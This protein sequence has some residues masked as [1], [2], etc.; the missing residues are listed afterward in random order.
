MITLT[1]TLEKF[2]QMGEKTGWT[3]ITVP[4]KT[5]QKLKPGNR[6]S[7]RV[8]GFLDDYAIQKTALIPMGEGDFIIPINAAMRKGLGKQKGA[9]V[10]V[11]LEV[12]AAPM[13]PP[14][15]LMECLMDEPEALQ[16][17]NS[18]PQ[19]H[20][21]YF[22]KWID[23]A[24]TEPTKAKRIALVIKTMIRKMDFG[25]MLREEREER[26]KLGR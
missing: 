11:K 22:T 16:Y 5:A 10:K 2:G 6:Q 17:F 21:N 7:F 19:S 15:E 18:L 13:L 9:T 14:A 3:Y 8:K 26:K 25:A 23:S 4:A 24:K 1:A 12:D 20:R